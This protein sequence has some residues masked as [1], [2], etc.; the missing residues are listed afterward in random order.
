[1]KG[2]A[3]LEMTPEEIETVKTIFKR[4]VNIKHSIPN[5]EEVISSESYFTHFSVEKNL[6]VL[7]LL[8]LTITPLSFRLLYL[9]WKSNLDREKKD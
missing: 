5:K 4:W 2:G 7:S 8:L 1:L 3:N 6:L 9:D